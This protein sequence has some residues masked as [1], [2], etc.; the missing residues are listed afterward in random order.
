MTAQLTRDID[1]SQVDEWAVGLVVREGVLMNLSI[2][3]KMVAI[4]EMT[5][6]GISQAEQASRLRT[7]IAEIECLKQ[8]LVRIKKRKQSVS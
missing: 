4:R 7:N 6:L 5:K 2:P 3:E 8:R 1:L